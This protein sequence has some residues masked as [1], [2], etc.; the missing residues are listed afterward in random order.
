MRALSD[1]LYFVSLEKYDLRVFIF[2]FH[3][4]SRPLLIPFLAFIVVAICSGVLDRLPVNEGIHT[5]EGE[6]HPFR[7]RIERLST[8]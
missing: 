4:F 1:G 6:D 2:R 7:V 3:L 8:T 5:D